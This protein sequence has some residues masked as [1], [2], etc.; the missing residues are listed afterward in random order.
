MSFTHLFQGHARL[1]IRTRPA[2][3]DGMAIGDFIDG[4]DSNIKAHPHYPDA[5]LQVLGGVLQAGRALVAARERQ[6]W[7]AVR[8]KV[9][10]KARGFVTEAE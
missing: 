6:N 1:S 3:I 8:T 10:S 4:L 5:V 7:A 9:V 2:A